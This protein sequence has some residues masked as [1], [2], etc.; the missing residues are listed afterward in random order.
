MAGHCTLWAG[1]EAE[2]TTLREQ[3][4]R[5]RQQ[6]FEAPR[7]NLRFSPVGRHV[8]EKTVEDLFPHNGRD[9]LQVTL[10]FHSA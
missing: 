9:M 2:H 1:L 10:S 7:G 3:V 8:F 4:A 6:I 5:V